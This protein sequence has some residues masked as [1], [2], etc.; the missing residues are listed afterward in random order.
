VVGVCE[1]GDESVGSGA[2]ELVSSNDQD[3][4]W[5]SMAM[6][7]N[8]LKYQPLEQCVFGGGV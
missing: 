2:K 6:I 5:E 4:T 3:Q 1:H 7:F 8:I